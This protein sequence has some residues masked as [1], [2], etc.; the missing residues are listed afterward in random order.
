M[1]IRLGHL[2]LVSMDTLV[3]INYQPKWQTGT[4]RHDYNTRVSKTKL[5]SMDTLDTNCQLKW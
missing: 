1:T 2:R 5:L 4:M 3:D